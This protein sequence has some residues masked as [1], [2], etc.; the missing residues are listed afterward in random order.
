M[1]TETI[2]AT[3]LEI[4]Q[5]W[6]LTDATAS[7]VVRPDSPVRLVQLLGVQSSVGGDGDLPLAMTPLEPLSGGTP[8]G[9]LQLSIPTDPE[10]LFCFGAFTANAHPSLR[11]ARK[12]ARSDGRQG[13][14]AL[15]SGCSGGRKWES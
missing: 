9:D 10:T 15:G 14:P 4:E 8:E 12:G 11:C 13:R 5:R 7:D 3:L 2:L 6:R 1:T